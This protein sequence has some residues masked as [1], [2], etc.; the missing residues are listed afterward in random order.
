MRNDYKMAL[1]E[2]VRL[3]ECL[4]TPRT[5]RSKKEAQKVGSPPT[6]RKNESPAS[7]TRVRSPD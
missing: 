4:N 6:F 3:R 7:M 2:I 1:E 5:Q